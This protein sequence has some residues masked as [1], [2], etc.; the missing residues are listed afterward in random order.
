MAR[1]GSSPIGVVQAVRRWPVG[2][3][4]TGGF[5]VQDVHSK[6]NQSQMTFAK[7]SFTAVPTTRT[8]DNTYEYKYPGER[9]PT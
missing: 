2:W 8:I 4:A 5:G 9:V 3:R 6:Y 1:G 7:N